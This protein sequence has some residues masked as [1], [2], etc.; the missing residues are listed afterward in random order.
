[1]SAIRYSDNVTRDE[2]G[3]N[4]QLNRERFDR[5]KNELLFSFFFFRKMSNKS[6]IKTGFSIDT[7]ARYR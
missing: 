5:G 7:H 6:K 4:L 1:M 2:N 3:R